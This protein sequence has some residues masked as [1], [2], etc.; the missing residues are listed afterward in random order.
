M[1][2]R[3][4]GFTLIEVAIGLLILTLVLGAALV[5][6]QAR[7]EQRAYALTDARLELAQEALIG[8]AAVNG[9]L[10][11]PASVPLGPENCAVTR[12]FLPLELGIQTTDF[13]QAEMV[14]VVEPSY[15]TVVGFKAA[16]QLPLIQ[17]PG[18]IVPLMPTLKLCNTAV[19]STPTDCADE[20]STVGRALAVVFSRGMNLSVAGA[21]ADEIENA[22]LDPVFVQRTRGTAGSLGGEYDDAVVGLTPFR[23][24][25]T[26]IK[27]QQLP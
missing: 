21:S 12:G 19:G 7:M 27:A 13:W 6:L 4:R 14:Y 15:T 22:D 5:P 3:A 26:M 10:P 9:R 20:P 16:W 24:F 8:F 1:K 18:P 17:P 11:C 23:L 2:Q 25:G